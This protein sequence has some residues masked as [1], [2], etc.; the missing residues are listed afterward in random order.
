VPPPYTYQ[1]L[2]L[3]IKFYKLRMKK[4]GKYHTAKGRGD[5]RGEEYVGRILQNMGLT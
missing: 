5:L 3:S 4:Q 2:N 1:I